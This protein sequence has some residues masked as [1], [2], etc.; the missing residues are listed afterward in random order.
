MLRTGQLAGDMCVSASGSVPTSVPF[1]TRHAVYRSV[2]V[3]MKSS[4]GCWILIVVVF[5]LHGPFQTNLV[6]GQSTTPDFVQIQAELND[7]RLLWF[8]QMVA[9]RY[10]YTYDFFGF[11]PPG[12][13]MPRLAEVNETGDMELLLTMDGESAMEFRRWVRTVEEAFAVIQE[14]IDEQVYE[15]NVTF[16]SQLGFPTRTYIDWDDMIC[17]DEET[18]YFEDLCGVC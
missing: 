15:L 3:K 4:F 10:Q 16:D 14:A 5:F 7:A 1:V 12:Y 18:F 8:R 11:F 2:A 13:I 6:H 17:D 9:K